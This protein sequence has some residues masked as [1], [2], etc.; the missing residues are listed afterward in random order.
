MAESVVSICNRALIRLGASPILSLSDPSKEARVMN[1]IYDSVRKE[2]LRSH[3]WNFA[4]RRAILASESSSPEFEFLYQYVLP[5][6]CLRVIKSHDQIY[7]F[8]VENNRIF[9]DD[10]VVYLIY[11]KDVIDPTEFDSSFTTCLVLK[12]AMEAAY[13]ITNNNSLTAQLQQ[14]YILARREA[15]QYDAQEGTP[16]EWMNFE[17]IDVR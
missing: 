15:K 12:L 4:T 17:W 10:S 7:K 6:D 8:K 11:I 1:N 2:L 5:S 3:L 9:T 13:A 14:E 16:D